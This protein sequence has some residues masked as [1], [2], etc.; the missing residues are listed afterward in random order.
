MFIF[1]WRKMTENETK[2]LNDAWRLEDYTDKKQSIFKII[3]EN[4]LLQEIDVTCNVIR[5]I[6]FSVKKLK[7]MS[8]TSFQ[9]DR[10]KDC[11]K[12]A[13]RLE[14]MEAKHPIFLENKAR[15]SIELL[16]LFK[17]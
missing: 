11:F 8:F 6:H 10:K 12:W 16:W 13:S 4:K 17:D 7:L 15:K 2:I 14:W 5:W 9:C 1:T 3:H